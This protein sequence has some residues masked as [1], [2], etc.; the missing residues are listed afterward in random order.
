MKS[1]YLVDASSMFFRAYYAVKTPLTTSEGFPT[2]ALYGF[3]QMTIKLLNDVAPDYIAYCFDRK[4]PSFRKELFDDYKANRGQMPDDLELQVPYLRQITE[5]L[6]IPSFDKLG[7]EADDLIGTLCNVAKTSLKVVIVSGDKDFAQLVGQNVTMWDTMKDVKYDNNA[8][9]KKWGVKPDQ[10]IDYL[11]IC[12]DS[13]D[14]VPGV[15]GIGQKGAGKLLDQFNSL[16]DIYDNL[17]KIKNE[18]LK[19]KLVKGKDE[20]FLS[21]E[22]VS[23]K[24][25]IKGFNV[26]IA[27][28]KQKDIDRMNVEKLLK[29]LEFKFFEK[30]LLGTKTSEKSNDVTVKKLN[31]Q[32]LKEGDTV[33]GFSYPGGVALGKDKFLY[34]TTCEEEILEYLDHLKLNWRGFDPKALFRELGFTKSQKVVWSTSLAVYSLELKEVGSFHEVYQIYL[35]EKLPALPKVQDLYAAHL[36]LASILEGRIN[37][38][39]TKDVYYKIELPLAKVLF[40]MELNGILLDTNYLKLQ[41]D[42]LKNELEKLSSQIFKLAGSEFNISSPKQLAKVLF[43]D[44]GL[45]VIKTKK[46]GP[47]TD[48]SVLEILSN[49]HP[50][51]NY[52]IEYREITKLKSTYVDVLPTIVNPD[53]DRIHTHFRQSSVITG[54]LSS[55]NPNLQNIPIKTKR[56]KTIRKA[57]IAPKGSKLVSG[58]LFSNRASSSGSYN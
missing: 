25:K 7:Y 33:W 6:G 24:T 27:D 55:V 10:M 38:S 51:I 14:N 57:F 2:G 8:V 23:I 35:N 36:E 19:Q 34:T 50:I 17:D 16:E 40:D 41:S 32:S 54:R 58:R 3:I 49:A 11:A 39:S 46:T 31:K 26:D 53:T 9:I 30:T 56:G 28:L 20:A 13:S 48:S 4:E 44:L 29:K 52:L 42:K 37:K 21:K 45:K 15:Y 47:S 22:L 18:K 43:E 12:G 1:L 5:A